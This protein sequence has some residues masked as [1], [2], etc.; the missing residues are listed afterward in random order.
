MI[1]ALRILSGNP[2]SL[3]GLCLVVLVILAAL[4]APWIAP[5][6]T[7]NGAVV[8]FAF[9]NI[10]Q[11]PPNATLPSGSRLDKMLTLSQLKQNKY[12][13]DVDGNGK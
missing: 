2:L 10:A 13:L 7:H 9:A 1:R 12:I 11:K 3:F 8:D 6:P 5:F 4:L